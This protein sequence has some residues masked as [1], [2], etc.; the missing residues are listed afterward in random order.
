MTNECGIVRDLLP[1]YKEKMTSEESDAFIEKHL[2]TCSECRS[3]M[4][5]LSEEIP[6]LAEE[7]DPVPLQQLSRKYHKNR[8]E[9]IL[10]SAAIV[11]SVLVSL[12]AWLTKPQYLFYEDAV[13]EVRED[14]GKITIVFTDQAYHY[15]LDTYTD[16][17]SEEQFTDVT[18]WTTVLDRLWG[19]SPSYTA[20][21][22]QGNIWYKANQ[23]ISTDGGYT[24]NE[25]RDVRISGDSDLHNITL[26]R[27]TLNYYMLMSAGLSLVLLIIWLF[28]K[29][30]MLFRIF[31]APFSWLCAHI[32]VEQGLHGATFTLMRDFQLICILCIS[33]YITFFMV[34]RRYLQMKAIPR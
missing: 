28:R 4:N 8:K 19:Q 23:I 7:E 16:P 18:C 13:Q 29:N 17:D 31:L 14:N 20:V 3:Y 22:D 33:L 10:L 27:L 15:D 2:E 34:H 11:F 24:V 12:F 5:S 26:R 1:L 21:L 32:I 25:H 6:V 9:T 30:T